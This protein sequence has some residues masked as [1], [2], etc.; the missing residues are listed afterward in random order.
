MTR[1]VLAARRRTGDAERLTESKNPQHPSSWH[2]SGSSSPSRRRRPETNVDVMILPM[3]GDDVSGWKPGKAH[4]VFERSLTSEA[5]PM[6][7]PDG[8]W[9]AYSSSRVRTAGSSTC[10]RSLARGPV[11][12]WRAEPNPTWSRSKHELFY[13]VNGRIM[14]TAF[15]I[16]GDSFSAGKPHEWSQGRY[17]TRGSSRMF[18]LHPDGERFAMAPAAQPS[19]EARQGSLVL[20]F[21]FFEELRRIEAAPKP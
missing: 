3:E 18:D 20:I 16:N 12:D 10:G 4:G 19:R 8:R 7:S 21:D 13:G 2:P 9:L 17:Q 14:V 15:A 11:A 1:T 5:D 6:F